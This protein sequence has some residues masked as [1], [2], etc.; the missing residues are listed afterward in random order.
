MM[1]WHKWDKWAQY[2]QQYGYRPPM[3]AMLLSQGDVS[4]FDM[5]KRRIRERRRCEKCGK[6]QD[7]IVAELYQ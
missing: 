3:S 4:R 7:R 2:E 5:Q 6:M 1:C